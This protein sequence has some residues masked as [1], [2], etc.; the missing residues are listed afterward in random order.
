MGKTAANPALST[1]K[2]FRDEY[3]AHVEQHRCPA[4]VCRALTTF[5]ISAQKCRACGKCLKACPAEAISG[6]RKVAHV[7][8]E[9]KCIQCGACRDVCPFDAVITR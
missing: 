3:L 2:Y 8:E 6:A 5:A 9:S 7:I 4:G 1:L